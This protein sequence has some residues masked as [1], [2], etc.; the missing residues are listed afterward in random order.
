[1]GMSVETRVGKRHT[2]YLP[3]E[4]VEATGLEEG[5]KILLR[6]Q[7]KTII[8]EPLV[9]P[10]KLALTGEKYA[11][12]KPEQIEELSLSEQKKRSKGSA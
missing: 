6:V 10:L 3:K 12:M 7:G 11:S 2:I 4:V 1:M 9:D 5:E 8:V